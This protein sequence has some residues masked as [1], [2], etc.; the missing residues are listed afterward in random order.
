MWKYWI[1]EIIGL[2]LLH[3]AIGMLL[4]SVVNVSYVAVQNE[5]QSN[6]SSNN[7]E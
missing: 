2:Q 6:Y 3:E 5:E 1:N 4:E 7:V